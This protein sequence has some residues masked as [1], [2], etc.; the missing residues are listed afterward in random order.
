[1]MPAVDVMTSAATDETSGVLLTVIGTITTSAG[2][3]R[4]AFAF[5]TGPHTRRPEGTSSQGLQVLVQLGIGSGRGAALEGGPYAAEKPA[6]CRFR[7][8]SRKARS[9]CQLGMPTPL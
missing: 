8:C 1:M 7:I 6:S 5:A 9:W 3:G 4:A 2:E